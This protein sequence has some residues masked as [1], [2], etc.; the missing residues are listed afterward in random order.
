MGLPTNHSRLHA[1]FRGG[2]PHARSSSKHYKTTRA[3][4]IDKP[5]KRNSVSSASTSISQHSPS[6]QD[7]DPFLLVVGWHSLLQKRVFDGKQSPHVS[8]QYFDDA[9]R[10]CEGCCKKDPGVP[11]TVPSVSAAMQSSDMGSLLSPNSVRACF[12][13]G[14][15]CTS[16]AINILFNQIFKT[17]S[18]GVGAQQ[19]C[20]IIFLP[21]RWR[22]VHFLRMYVWQQDHAYCSRKVATLIMLLLAATAK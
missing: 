20:I 15:A 14:L 17:F 13:I 7:S 18:F 8:S 16:Y 5:S 11:P 3:Q 21:F 1:F 6:V 2:R 9:L 12:M 19:V 22:S 10:L 4:Q